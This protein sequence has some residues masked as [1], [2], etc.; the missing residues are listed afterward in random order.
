[1]NGFMLVYFLFFLLNYHLIS[2]KKALIFHQGFGELIDRAS[3][4]ARFVRWRICA[5]HIAQVVS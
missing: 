5:V 2:Q 3:Q 4:P 1:M